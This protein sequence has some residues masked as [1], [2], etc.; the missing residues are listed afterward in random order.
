MPE[1]PEA[2]SIARKL[3]TI[4]A[5]KA[6]ILSARVLYDKNRTI[7]EECLKAI[8]EDAPLHIERAFSRGKRVILQLRTAN[9]QTRFLFSTLAMTGH[10]IIPHTANSN[11]TPP[12]PTTDTKTKIE[13][14][15]EPDSEK[16]YTPSFDDYEFDSL[17][18]VAFT[19][20][21][22]E[23]KEDKASRFYLIF[24]DQRKFGKLEYLTE[25]ELTEKS[26]E[27]GPDILNDE[28]SI[29]SFR[30][31]FRKT[32][33]KKRASSSYISTILLDQ[34]VISGIGNYMRADILYASKL[35]PYRVVSDLSDSDLDQLR[36]ACLLV[37][38]TSSE[39][40]G[41]TI[42]NYF[43]PD[44]SPGTYEALVYGRKERD[45]NTVQKDSLAGRSIY[46]SPD[47]QK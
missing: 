8:Q 3:N 17:D 14:E 22:N 34:K 23:T 15:P 44:G 30:K 32:I 31:I 2:F 27:L 12:S 41:H 28:L 19:C 42:S 36:E 47:I 45:G 1:G 21:T 33:S 25:E 43:L 35:S 11:S 38:N 10:W 24:R 39:A 29:E 13:P 37:G 4:L 40:G 18:R 9:R 26:S 7:G 6:S 20:C 16:E 46:W 5:D